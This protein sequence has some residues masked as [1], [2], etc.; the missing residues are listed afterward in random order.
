MLL[1][2]TLAASVLGL[3]HVESL[4]VAM[5][6]LFPWKLPQELAGTFQRPA[7][8]SGWH[9]LQLHSAGQHARAQGRGGE[10]RG[11]LLLGVQEEG[12]KCPEER[13]AW[14]ASLQARCVFFLQFLS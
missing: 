11:T 1:Q 8:G 14:L 9:L 3:C 7:T 6:I 4:P 13:R 2:E 12:K 10:S 5:P